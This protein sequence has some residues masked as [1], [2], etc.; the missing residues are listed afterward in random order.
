MAELFGFKPADL[1]AAAL[2]VVVVLM[3]L[4]GRLVP[5]RTYDDLKEDRN[6]WRTAHGESEKARVEA[7]RQNSELIELSRTGVHLL[8]SLPRGEVTA[9]GDQTVAP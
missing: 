1:G 5:R 2:L 3:V 9:D 8:G 7:M 4:T 6:D